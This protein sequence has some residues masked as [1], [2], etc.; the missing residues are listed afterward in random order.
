MA[1]LSSEKPLWVP[2][3]EQVRRS[4]LRR[5]VDKVGLAGAADE[6]GVDY[7]HLYEWSIRHPEKFWPAMWRYAGVIAYERLGKDPWDEVVM[8]LDRMTPPHPAFVL[9]Q[10]RQVSAWRRAG[11]ESPN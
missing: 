4:H 1:D 6:S 3:A 2:S 7:Q 11:R 10:S 9:H 5:F 8:G